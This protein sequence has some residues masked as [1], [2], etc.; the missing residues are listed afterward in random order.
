MKAETGQ[1]AFYSGLEAERSVA[2]HC[3]RRGCRFVAHRFRGTAGEIDLIVEDDT[4]LIFVEVK[5]SDTH[6]AAMHA[7]QPRQIQRLFST[8]EEFLGGRPGGLDTAARFDLA[9]VDR[10]GT[11][12]I[13]ENALVA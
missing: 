9:T 10:T 1:R 2:R 6:A 11:V 8:A 3:L 4:S 7:L 5:T 12:E 13:T